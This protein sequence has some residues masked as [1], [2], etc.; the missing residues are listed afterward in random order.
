MFQVQLY[1]NLYPLQLNELVSAKLP[2]LATQEP[3]IEWM[4]PLATQGFAEFAD[5]DFLRVLGLDTEENAQKLFAF[6]P[7]GGPRWDALARVRAKNSEAGVLLVE[8]KSHV[9]ELRPTQGRT[10]TAKQSIDKIDAALK[11]TQDWLGVPDER[12]ASWVGPLYQTANRLA[13]LHFLRCHLG[14]RAW[15]AHILFVN[16]PTHRPPL[17]TPEPGWRHALAAAAK[18]LGLPRHISN[19]GH[20]YIN[21]LSHPTAAAGALTS[22]SAAAQEPK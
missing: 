9:Q 22:Q 3:V 21:G 18:E 14:I 15:L 13:F 10:A 16:D 2:S 6:W 8:A 19:Y 17:Q 11:E 4:S 7:E 1:V 12:R 20:V 5:R